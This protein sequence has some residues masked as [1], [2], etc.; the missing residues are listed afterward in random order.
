MLYVCYVF[1]MKS[2]LILQTLLVFHQ[3]D[4]DFFQETHKELCVKIYNTRHVTSELMARCRG[5][6]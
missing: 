5:L 2:S 1:Y 4:G 3:R 6:A